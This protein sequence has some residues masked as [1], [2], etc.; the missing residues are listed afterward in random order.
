MSRFECPSTSLYLSVLLKRR[1]IWIGLVVS[2]AIHFSFTAWSGLAEEEQMVKPLTTQFI[3]RQPRL[4]KPL[5]LKK[6]PR[7]K[8]RHI[9]RKMVSVKARVDRR[10]VSSTVLP[11]QLVGSL[12]RP[13]VNVRHFLCNWWEVLHDLK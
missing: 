7:P 9:Q 11:M 1:A 8:R 6:R 13:E 3:K 10:D 4:T 12:A 5:E 2:V